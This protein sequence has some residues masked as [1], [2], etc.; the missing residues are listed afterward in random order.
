MFKR[1]AV[2][3]M[4]L[5]LGTVAGATGQVHWDAPT[6]FSP[7]PAEDIGLYFWQP[8][9]GRSDWAAGAIWRQHGNLSLGVR[10][11]YADGGDWMLGAEFFGPINLLG[12]GTGL[13]T[14]WVLGFGATFDGVTQLRVPVGLSVGVNIGQPGGIQLLPYVHPRVAVDLLAV[15]GRRPRGDGYG[16]QLRRGRRRGCR[17]RRC[18]RSARGRDSGGRRRHHVRRRHRLSIHAAPHRTLSTFA[19]RPP[20]P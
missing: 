1:S 20:H 18:I 7:R 10:G 4:G 19:S 5:L 15:D 8:D 13:L 17:P 2:L 12:P 3:V 11:G 9:L 14:S 6:F 16:I